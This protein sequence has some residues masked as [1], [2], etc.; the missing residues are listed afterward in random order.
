MRRKRRIKDEEEGARAER[1]EKR[2]GVRAGN[3]EERKVRRGLGRRRG[4]DRDL[5]GGWVR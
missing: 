2:K 5:G 1:K 3:N 4:N